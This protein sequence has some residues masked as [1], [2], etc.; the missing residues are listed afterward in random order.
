MTKWN[1]TVDATEQQVTS[2][3]RIKGNSDRKDYNAI[4][5]RWRQQRLGLRRRR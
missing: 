2:A 1:A 5:A 3:P 4:K